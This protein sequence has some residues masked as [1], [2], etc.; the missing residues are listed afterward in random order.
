MMGRLLY[1]KHY[2]FVIKNLNQWRNKASIKEYSYLQM[3][4]TQEIRMIR[5]WLNRELMTWVH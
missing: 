5:V 1:L 3:K 2:G 4:I